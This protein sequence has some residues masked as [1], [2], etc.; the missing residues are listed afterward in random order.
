MKSME[1]TGAIAPSEDFKFPRDNRKPRTS[2]SK[3]SESRRHE[4]AALSS[5]SRT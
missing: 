3:V 5:G 1:L 2:K 4:V